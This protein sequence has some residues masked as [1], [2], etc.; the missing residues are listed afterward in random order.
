MSAVYK[1][2]PDETLRKRMKGKLSIALRAL[3][4]AKKIEEI[5]ENRKQARAS[6]RVPQRPYARKAA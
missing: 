2:Q 4:D 5:L 3:E 6:T 1:T